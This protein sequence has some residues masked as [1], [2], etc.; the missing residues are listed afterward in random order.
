MFLSKN[1]KKVFIY[2]LLTLLA[3]ICR[4]YLFEGRDSWHDEWHSIYVADPNISTELTMQ[5]FYGDK[6]DTFLTEYYPPLYLFI[7]KYFFMIFG[8]TD[9]NG[10]WLSIIF[11]TL[12]VPLSMYLIEILTNSKKYYFVSFLIILN[13]FLTW[14]SIEIRAHSLL[15]ALALFNIIMFYKILE[16]RVIYHQIIYILS[17]VFLLSVWPIT[18]AIFFGKTVFLIK[19]YLINKKLE[20]K[21][22]LIFSL[23]LISYI[24]FNIDYLKFNLARDFHYT[25]LYKSFFVNYHFRTFFGSIIL[26]GIFLIIFSYLVLTNLKEIIYSNTKQN[27]IIYIIISSY[28]LTLLYTFFRASIMSPKYV[29]F[30]VPLIILWISIKLDDSKIKLYFK[31]IKIFLILIS[32]VFF[33]INIDD[34]PINRPP[35]KNVLHDVVSNNIKLIVTSENEVFNNYL[36]T[37]NNIIKNNIKVITSNEIIPDNINNF[38]FICLN[39]P[40][41]AVGDLGKLSNKTKIEP[42]CL[43]FKQDDSFVEKLPI[44]NNTQDYLIRKFIRKKN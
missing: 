30:I 15:V 39:N 24:F 2:F 14:Q 20:I 40:R 1:Y 12:T 26:G 3:F 6:G 37:K 13:L 29:I 25:S 18:G 16:N 38:W 19:E 9:D 7:L 22:F 33:T 5:R 36:R 4:F 34:S 41:F 10:R 8:Y 44:L 21:I 42:E 17:S 32:L 31:K 43:D 27:I 35:T 11:G 23:I 28:F